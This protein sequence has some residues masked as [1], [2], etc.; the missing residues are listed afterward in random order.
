MDL[1]YFQFCRL[2]SPFYE[3]GLDDTPDFAFASEDLPDNW[4]RR[5]DS[6]WCYLYP[7]SLDGL[8]EQGWK[9]HVSATLPKTEEFLRV[10]STYCLE[11]ELMFK[12]IRGPSVLA[13][14]NSKYGDRTASG[15]FIAVFPKDEAELEKVLTD[16]DET[17]GGEPSP[18]ILSDLRYGRGPVYVRYGGFVDLLARDSVGRIVHCIRDPEGKLVPDER[19]PVFRP[20][21]WVSIPACL[22]PS[23]TARSQGRLSDFP[24]RPKRAL[25]FSN[26]GGVYEAI[27]A[28]TEEVVLM[29]EA[30]PYAGLDEEGR[31]A[32]A[33]LETEH[34]A[35][36]MLAGV[37]AI[38]RV[39]EYRKGFEHFYLVREMVQGISLLECIQRWNPLIG[40][41]DAMSF[42][43]YA[44][45]SL[46][47]LGSI[48]R[49]LEMMHGRGVVFGDVHPNNVLVSED[50]SIHFIDF[51]GSSPVQEM[52]PQRIAAPGFRAPVGY[53][54]P[55]VDRYGL[56]CLRIEMFVPAVVTLGW[57]ET[58]LDQLLDVVGSSFPVSDDFADQVRSDLGPN[59]YPGEGP[60]SATLR[61]DRFEDE[62]DTR[63]ELLR[64]NLLETASLDRTDRLFPGDIHQFL[65]PGGGVNLSTGSAGV[66]FALKACDMAIEETHVEWTR[67]RVRE[68]R[69]LRPGL[70]D[71]LA[72]IAWAFDRIGLHSEA[73]ELVERLSNSEIGGLGPTLFD[74][75]A[76]VALAMLHF[77][78]DGRNEGLVSRAV[79]IADGLGDVS[80]VNRNGMVLGGLLH[81]LSGVALL[82]LRLAE[83]LDEPW[84]LDLA[85][86]LISM[87]LQSL[88]W[89]DSV[90]PTQNSLWASPFLGVGGGGVLIVLN[91]LISLNPD[92]LLRTAYDQLKVPLRR[93][94]LTS[95]GLANGRAGVILALATIRGDTEWADE[96]I[97]Q[98]LVDLGW[99]SVPL[100]NGFGVL[101]EGS[102]RLSCDLST[103]TAGVLL[104]L[105][106]AKPNGWVRL[107][108]LEFEPRK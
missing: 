85:E 100:G 98:H 61:W 27:N 75:L 89:S 26:G 50:G 86:K 32:V 11:R 88:G 90:G 1:R 79:E 49:T 28:N 24:Y 3:A 92:S 13:R 35:L 55:M 40:G 33:R 5:L 39:I 43:D 80:P 84:R 83:V 22:E 70:F 9:I 21:E 4:S 34:W 52:K 51:E 18:Y 63:A 62:G 46:G 12:F 41:P 30:R 29:K 81:G 104:A 48:D 37:D 64:R 78:S 57:S 17:I 102:L 69:D 10:V 20:P 107:P 19:K 53:G 16:L 72:G 65:V 7:P 45:W 14:R 58:K 77:G 31:D 105:E 66:L 54:G 25:H 15:K 38:P 87:D 56:G 42:D 95:A 91:R 106:A 68:L 99:H 82:H 47:I 67:K 101:G 76:G 36:E 108:F 6:E 44:K 97:R 59:P 103:G 2:E 96:A 23:L 73:D 60:I 74:G 71:G 94:G 93:R 8:P